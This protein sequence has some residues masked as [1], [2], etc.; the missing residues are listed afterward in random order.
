LL[1]VDGFGHFEFVDEF[2]DLQKVFFKNLL[3]GISQQTFENHHHTAVDLRINIILLFFF[4]NIRIDLRK[5]VGLLAPVSLR[6]LLD[7][8]IDEFKTLLSVSRFLLQDDVVE[9]FSVFV[10]SDLV[11][12][13]ELGMLEQLY[14]H[15]QA[16]VAFIWLIEIVDAVVHVLF[17]LLRDVYA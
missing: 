4:E 17:D 10:L 15:H 8:F 1:V 5:H 2:A 7:A 3:V 12:S 9:Q 13:D 6:N 11:E 16:G 14:K